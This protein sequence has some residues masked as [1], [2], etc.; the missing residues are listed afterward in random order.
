[1]SAPL[2]SPRERLLPS[3]DVL[4]EA[5]ALPKLPLPDELTATYGGALGFPRLH[6]TQR[7][8]P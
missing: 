2:R 5:P 6:A 1:M 7:A 8:S 3:L 4:L